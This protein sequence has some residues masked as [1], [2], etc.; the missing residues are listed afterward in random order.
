MF[1]VSLLGRLCSY[2]DDPLRSEFHVESVFYQ[3]TAV[4]STSM[5]L[6]LAG[7]LSLS[8]IRPHVSSAASER[9]ANQPGIYTRSMAAFMIFLNVFNATLLSFLND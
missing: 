6:H 1:G 4:R 2:T 3:T 5:H 8:C 7:S 9:P